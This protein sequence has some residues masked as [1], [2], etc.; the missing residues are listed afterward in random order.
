MM[1][2]LPTNPDLGAAGKHRRAWLWASLVFVLLRSI[3]NISYPIG[4][5]QATYLVI[6][7]GLLGGQHLYQDLW[8]NKPPGIFYL[9]A[10]IVK[11]FG[12]VMWCVGVV[13]ILWLLVMS[14]CVFR[15]A[16]RYLGVGA[17][18][19]AV[20]VSATWHIDAGYWEAAQTETFLILF[21]FLAFFSVAREGRW[22]GVRH[23]LAGVLCG[24]AFWLKY[25]AIVM[26]PLVVLLPYVDTRGLDEEPRRV[27]FV[28]AWRE[29]V[30]RTLAFSAGF[31]AS[32]AVVLIAFRFSDAWEALKEVQFEVLPRYSAMALERTPNYFLWASQQTESV[33][34]LWT[35]I[36]FLIAFVV[37]WKK[38]ELGRVAPVLLAAVV[39]YL[40]V[41][42]QVRFHAYGFETAFPF[43]A[44]VWGYLAVTT[45]RE[46]RLIAGMCSERGWKLARLLVWVLFANIVAWPLPGQTVNVL[47]HYRA[48]GDWVRGPDVFYSSY[49]WANPISHF[50]DQMQVISYLRRNLAP[51]DSVFVWGSEPLIY[52]L[53]SRPCPARFVTNLALLSP[54]SPPA[55]RDEMVRRLAKSPPRFLVVARDD[56][57][58]NI[59]YS[60]WDSEEFLQAYPEFAIFIADYYER[61]VNLRNFAIYQRRGSLPAE[62]S[63]SSTS[64]QK[65]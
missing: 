29:W 40:C 22:L 64:L 21:I 57:V 27:G 15:F 35:E 52:F 62:M 55:W 11:I 46:F 7:R 3:P 45:F 39:G 25:N 43:F 26:A 58:P 33:L 48:L 36:A 56:A 18:A 61:T 42:L 50:P 54:W 23:A 32:V 34:G 19:V 51:D 65:R 8:D 17:A 53:T 41:A 59:A 28:I 4:R 63:T 47:A 13:D 37:A 38:R 9:T 10:I 31:A 1:A 2:D 30:R 16:E 5:D 12:P 44:M 49:P 14:Y 60:Q 24:A 20:V 6:G